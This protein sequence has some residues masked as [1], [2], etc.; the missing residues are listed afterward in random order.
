MRTAFWGREH[1]NQH[2]GQDTYVLC[3]PNIHPP[4]KERSMGARTRKMA[5]AAYIVMICG[6][7]ASCGS[8]G[9]RL[10]AY[11]NRTLEWQTRGQNLREALGEYF[12]G[13]LD[14]LYHFRDLFRPFLVG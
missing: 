2:F 10:A 11:K 7:W 5:L 9:D 14:K 13:E 1:V 3:S 8:D 6:L 12:A 4:G